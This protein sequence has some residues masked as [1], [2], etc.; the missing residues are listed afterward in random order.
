MNTFVPSPYWTS[1]YS[2]VPDQGQTKEAMEAEMYVSAE[3]HEL[4]EK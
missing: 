3:F 2:V 4:D 1:T